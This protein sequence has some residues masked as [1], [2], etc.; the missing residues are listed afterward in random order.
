M[1]SVTPATAEVLSAMQIAAEDI[2]AVGGIALK[3]KKKRMRGKFRFSFISG[4][5][6]G[7]RTGSPAMAISPSKV[8]SRP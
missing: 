8:R 5:E 6:R 2:L 7:R 1:Y 3:M 4:N